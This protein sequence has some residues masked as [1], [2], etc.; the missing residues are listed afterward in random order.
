MKFHRPTTLKQA[1][2]VLA[3]EENARCLAGGATLVAMMNASLVE[4]DALV[5]LTAVKGMAG[6]AQRKGGSVTIGAMTRHQAVA[7]FNGFAAGQRLI[8]DAAAEIGHPAIRNMGTIGGSISHADP[9]ADYPTAL[10]AAN[11]TIQVESTRGKREIDAAQF[12]TG[13]LETALEAG[14]MVTAVSIP[15][16]PPGTGSGYEKFARVQGDFATVAAAAVI[17]VEDGVCHFARLA[18]GACAPTP[19][20]SAEADARLIGSTL[21]EQAIGEAAALLAAQCDPVDDFR[22]SSEY[23]L[24]ILPAILA[25]AIAKAR[26]AAQ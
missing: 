25:R 21:D 15:P 9:A 13:Y 1:L 2:K 3:A 6:I 23:R 20:R 24:M 14:E 11:A 17:G 4:P 12:F 18:I 10:L 8:K 7:D 5:S 22:G 26:A 16:A 19:V